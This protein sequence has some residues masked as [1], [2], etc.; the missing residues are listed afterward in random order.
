MVPMQFRSKAQFVP[1]DS[2]LADPEAPF[3]VTAG[4]R[5]NSTHMH[6]SEYK[7]VRRNVSGKRVLGISSVQVLCRLNGTTKCHDR[8]L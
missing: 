2:A 6:T 5:A 1:E 3:S 7:D 8:Q 4:T